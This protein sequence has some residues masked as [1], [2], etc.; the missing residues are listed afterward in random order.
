MNGQALAARDRIA[1]GQVV[2]PHSLYLVTVDY[3]LAGPGRS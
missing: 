2:P 1:C 3:R